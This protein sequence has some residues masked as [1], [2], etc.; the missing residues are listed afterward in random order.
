MSMKRFW[1]YLYL[2]KPVRWAY[3]GALL[4]GVACGAMNGFGMPFMVYKI[5]PVLFANPSP[6]FWVMVGGTALFPAIFAVRGVLEF[7]NSYLASYTG[8][9]VL[10]DLQTRLFT[11]FQELPLA[12][13]ERSPVGDLMSRTQ[14]DAAAVQAVLTGVTNDLLRQPITL[15]GAVGALVYLSFQKQTIAFVLLCVATGLL[16]VLPVRIAGRRLRTQASRMQVKAGEVSAVLNEN[17]GAPKEVRVFGLEKWEINRFHQLLTQAGRANMRVTKYALLLSPVLE[18]LTAVGVGLAIAYAASQR[19]KLDTIIPLLTAL[20]M[21]YT[22]LKRLG[23]LHV[24]IKRGEASLDRLEEVLKAE[25]DV[26]DPVLPVAFECSRGE[27]GFENVDFRYSSGP[28]VLQGVN[29]TILPG[30][31]TAL[32]GPSGSGKTTLAKLILRFYDVSH[33]Q[34]TLDGVNIRHICKVDLRRAMAL[35]PQ[36][37]VL[38]NDT[39]ANNIRLGRTD[40]S[41]DDVIAAAHRAYADEF[42]NRLELGY[43]TIVGERGVRLSG[44]QKQRIALARAILKK[45]TILILDEATSALDP[46]SEQ[47]IQKALQELV[48]GKTVIIIAHRFSTIRMAS[49]ILLINGGRLEAEGSHDHLYVASPLYRGLYDRQSIVTL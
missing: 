17:L 6:S 41:D 5:L 43:N 36:D 8:M 2:L 20:Y 15:L 37:P 11:R 12:Y 10:V 46:D 24:H 40:A 31:V 21:T 27:I 4:F 44:G 16:I 22:P 34:V 23:A 28:M 30:R 3:L 1:P 7:L 9:R 25:D 26:A 47:M 42:I 29:A 18:F 39:V 33:G 49:R 35:V 38:F 45:A 13:I 48:P 14:N 19:M 32:V